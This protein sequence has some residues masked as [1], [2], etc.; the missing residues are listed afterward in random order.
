MEPTP[1]KKLYRSR[2][3]KI[4]AGVCGGLGEYFNLDPLIFRVIFIALAFAGGSG[5]GIYIVLALVMPNE[6][7]PGQ[8]E[9]PAE[10]GERVKDF[11]A[12]VK[13]S[14][15]KWVGETKGSET[16]SA[17]FQQHNRR[18]WLGILIVA[19]G[20]IALINQIFPQDWISWKLFWPILIIIVG[21][22][23][24]VRSGRR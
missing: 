9:K 10:V 21:L 19:I 1:Q 8:P 20:V 14:A 17:I 6:I 13:T 11:V 16:S 15:Q 23:L 24:V 2:T 3:E 5:F 7:L 4:I 18:H 12:D 22:S